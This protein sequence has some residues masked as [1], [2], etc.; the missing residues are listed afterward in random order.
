MTFVEEEVLPINVNLKNFL[1]I[2]NEVLNFGFNDGPQVNRARV[3]AWVNE[4]QYQIARQIE[5]P[6]FQEEAKYL[7]EAGVYELDLPEDFLRIQDFW[8]PE[9]GRRLRGVDLQ[10]Y[11][12]AGNPKVITGAPALY[13]LYKELLLLYPAPQTTGEEL[14]LHYIKEPP[15]LVNQTDVPLL[16]PNY[17]HLLIDYAI[18]RAFEGEDDYEAAQQF[19]GRYQRDLAAYGTDVQSRSVDRPVILDGTWSSHQENLGRWGG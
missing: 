11:N 6:E 15:A 1:G 9:L 13:T 4:A 16:N 3:E 7:T 5:A 18:C 14:F 12:Q 2:V 8:Y 17:W 19:Q 10:Q